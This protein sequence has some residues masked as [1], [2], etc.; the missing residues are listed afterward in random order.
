MPEAKVD[1]SVAK[2]SGEATLKGLNEIKIAIGGVFGYLI[3][4]FI[5]I[6]GNMVMRSV[7]EE[8]PTDHRDHHLV[9][10]AVPA[11]DG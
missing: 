2:S 3:M 10:Q 5:I 6:Y 7:I 9:G 4:M 8:K 11:H 1:I